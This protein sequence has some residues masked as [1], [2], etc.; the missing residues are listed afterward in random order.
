MAFHAWI[1]VR[2][3]VRDVG[4]YTISPGLWSY[5]MVKVSLKISFDSGRLNFD[6]LSYIFRMFRVMGASK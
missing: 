5:H 1:V 3:E 2:K 6:K 4:S